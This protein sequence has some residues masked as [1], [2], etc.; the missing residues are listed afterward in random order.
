V[1]PKHGRLPPILTPRLSTPG[2]LGVGR[3]SL[4]P[5]AQLGRCSGESLG[6]FR[7]SLHQGEV[8][9]FWRGV[10]GSR[11]R[12]PWCNQGA[13]GGHCRGHRHL[14]TR[15]LL[16]G[17]SS[18]PWLFMEPWTLQLGPSRRSMT[19]RLLV[20]RPPPRTLRDEGPDLRLEM[21]LLK[22]EDGSEEPGQPGMFGRP[23]VRCGLLFRTESWPSLPL[24]K[25]GWQP[26]NYSDSS[27]G[28]W[29]LGL[30]GPIVLNISGDTR[31]GCLVASRR[32]ST[33]Y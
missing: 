28:I 6:R 8:S 32:H 2:L 26:E 29:V 33:I 19:R 21:L 7:W 13:G 24:T 14:Q 20:S 30:L 22:G 11:P 31:P 10:S 23:V 17:A 27:G 3:G 1:L 9:R 15:A 5:R 18:W 12:Q 4:C 25:I 16:L